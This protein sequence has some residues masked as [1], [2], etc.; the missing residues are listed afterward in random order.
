MAADGLVARTTVPNNQAGAEQLVAWLHR[1]A[2][3]YAR[4]AVGVKATAV[5]HVP[6][7]EWLAQTPDLRFWQPTWYVLNPKGIQKFVRIAYWDP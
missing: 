7:M 1:H 6:L 5:C 2:A 4:R 3:P